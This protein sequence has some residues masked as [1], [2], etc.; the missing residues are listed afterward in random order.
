MHEFE[1]NWESRV[2]CFSY[3]QILRP[4]LG[5][6]IEHVVESDLK[7]MG[8]KSTVIEL[9]RPNEA[10]SVES[11]SRALTRANKLEASDFRW[12]LGIHQRPHHRLV[13]LHLRGKNPGS[14]RHS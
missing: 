5:S 13:T 11:R 9:K 2:F 10:Q 3:P 12:C 4:D 1:D 6:A 7:Q 14:A 8:D